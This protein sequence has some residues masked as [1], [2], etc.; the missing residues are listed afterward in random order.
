MQLTQ[1]GFNSIETSPTNREWA[2]GTLKEAPFW[3]EGMTPE[4]YDTEREYFARHWQAYTKGEY[5]P[6]WK[7]RKGSEDE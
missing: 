5:V 1:S 7:Q 4:E 3:R 2:T 6:L